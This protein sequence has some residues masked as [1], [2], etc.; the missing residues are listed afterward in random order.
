MWNWVLSL[1]MSIGSVARLRCWE[2][3][4]GCRNIGRTNLSRALHPIHLTDRDARSDIN[5]TRP[6]KL[7]QTLRRFPRS[8]PVQ[9]RPS[10]RRIVGETPLRSDVIKERPQTRSMVDSTS[11]I[12][13][14]HLHSPNQETF[15]MQEAIC[16]S[17]CFKHGKVCSAGKPRRNRT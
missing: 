11:A 2:R 8:K 4:A 10:L 6:L 14:F 7:V 1:N 13:L 9:R 5:P 3:L 15:I 16:P 12:L 17:L